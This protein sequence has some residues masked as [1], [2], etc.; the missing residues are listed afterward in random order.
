MRATKSAKVRLVSLVTPQV[1]LFAGQVATPWPG[2]AQSAIGKSECAERQYLTKTGFAED[3]QAD[4][5]AHGGPEKA[6][7]H[8]ASDHYALWR[9]DLGDNARF[10]PGGFGENISTLGLTEADVCIGDVFALGTARVQVSQGRQPCW[11]LAAHTG[12]DRM[13]YLVRKTLRTGWYYRVLEEG[14]V[15]PGDAMI[16][17]DRAPDAYTVKDVTRAYFDRRLDREEARSLAA[18][19]TLYLGWRRVF[20]DRAG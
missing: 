2:K 9:E 19:A 8:Y 4:L 3:F 12:E 13:A 6:L 17:M 1:T 15:S 7:H 14:E 18:I 10:V 5:V 20:A 11:K 16:L